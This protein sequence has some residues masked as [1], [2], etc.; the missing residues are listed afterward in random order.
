MALETDTGL[1]TRSQASATTQLA[2]GF[3]RSSISAINHG[4]ANQIFAKLT[5]GISRR[6]R[7]AT[8][9]VAHPATTGADFQR[10]N[11]G[12]VIECP[13]TKH[14]LDGGLGQLICEM[15]TQPPSAIRAVV[16]P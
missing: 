2:S 16:C 9:Q 11:W 4:D 15:Q 7:I 1:S 14:T 8:D 12:S 13:L 5:R 3:N 6:R 10:Q